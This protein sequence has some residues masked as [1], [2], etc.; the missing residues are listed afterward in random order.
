MPWIGRHSDPP[1]EKLVANCMQP[2]PRVFFF[3]LLGSIAQ[4]LAPS[5]EERGRRGL[6]TG[7]AARTSERASRSV[8]PGAA[9]ARHGVAVEL[10]RTAARYP[11]SQDRTRWAMAAGVRAQ[12][13]PRLARR[14]VHRPVSLVTVLIHPH[15]T[16]MHASADEDGRACV[17]GGRTG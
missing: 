1:P 8:V 12:A 10:N 4:T 6:C 9:A 5:T 2:L 11:T 7:S 17:R 15:P 13:G 3:F 14:G 16:H